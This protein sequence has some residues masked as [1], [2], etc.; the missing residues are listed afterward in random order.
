MVHVVMCVF[1]LDVSLIYILFWLQSSHSIPL[2]EVLG[3]I[4]LLHCV[5]LKYLV[6][7]TVE[8]LNLF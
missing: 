7:V 6:L 8:K 2:P 5:L 3:I 4:K 1:R